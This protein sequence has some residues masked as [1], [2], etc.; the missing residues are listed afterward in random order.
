LVAWSRGNRQ[1]AEGNPNLASAPISDEQAEDSTYQRGCDA[2]VA[3]IMGV[4]GSGKTTVGRALA[5]RLAWEFLEGDTLH[6]A[7]NVTKMAAGQPL[8]DTDRAPWLAAIASR[9]DAWRAAGKRGIVSCSA[10]KRRYRDVIIG[11][12]PGVRLVYLLG[13]PALIAER[14]AQRR[15]HFMPASLLDS[16][17][18]TLEPPAGDEDA[19][20]VSIDMPVEAI[21]ERLVIALSPSRTNTMAPA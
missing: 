7:A 3:V 4:S 6:P 12:R 19:I 18:A 5:Y 2:G 15:D 14:L 1:D 20:T 10:L 8:D 16:Q 21:V 9:I 11:D 13:A 17:F